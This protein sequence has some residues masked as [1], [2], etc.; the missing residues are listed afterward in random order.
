[1][2]LSFDAKLIP[3]LGELTVDQMGLME[4]RLKL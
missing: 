1:M 3:K 2:T 4:A